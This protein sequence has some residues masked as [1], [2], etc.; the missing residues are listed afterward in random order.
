MNWNNLN[1]KQILAIGE[2]IWLNLQEGA[3]TDNYEKFSRDLGKD[4]KAHV[5]EEEL[6]RQRQASVPDMGNFKEQTDF[7]A[8]LRHD[9]GV[10]LL[11]KV[12]FEKKPGEYLGRMLLSMEDDELKVIA[13]G[14]N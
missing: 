5:T 3:R 8:I 1:D 12:Y 4:M 11:W 9:F 7:I 6:L 14:V 10:T 2:P 13:A